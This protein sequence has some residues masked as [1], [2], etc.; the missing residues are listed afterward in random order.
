M[1]LKHKFNNSNNP[2]YNAKAIKE[3]LK[4]E[5]I[6]DRAKVNMYQ[7]EDDDTKDDYLSTAKMHIDSQLRRARSRLKRLINE[8]KVISEVHITSN[9][10]WTMYPEFI[11]DDCG[12]T[13]YKAPEVFEVD[14]TVPYSRKIPKLDDDGDAMRDED[15]NPIMVEVNMREAIKAASDNALKALK[16]YR[17]QS[18]ELQ[19]VEKTFKVEGLPFTTKYKAYAGNGNGG[20]EARV[21]YKDAWRGTDIE[22]LK[23]EQK[24]N[25]FIHM[26]AGT[27]LKLQAATRTRKVFETKKPLT[28]AHHVGVEIEFASMMDKFELATELTKENV[29]DF[30]QLKD[31]GSVKKDGEFNNAHE[32]CIVAPEAIIHEVVKRALRAIN[33]DGKSKV[34]EK[35][36]AGLHIHLDMRGRDRKLCFHNLAKAQ[37]IL[38]A[39]NPRSRT[40]G[41]TTKG[42]KDVVWSKRVDSSDFDTALAES[43]RER[44]YGI[45]LQA[46]S[47][48][49]TIEIRIHS[50]STNEEK[51]LNW[52]TILTKIVNMTTKIDVEAAKAE[53]FCDY[54]GLDQT[55]CD[56]INKRIAKFKDSSGKHVTVDEAA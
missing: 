40:D 16:V 22:Q 55:I 12:R 17:K 2:R 43:S 46:L 20:A 5:H 26:E 35:V 29:Q 53:T 38:Y 25:F 28:D 52:I 19:S 45:N 13:R 39:M 21:R 56:Y 44:Y 27:F 18:R 34:G 1:T 31:D 6:L 3:A 30:V 32:L 10:K 7:G 54:Y 37:R 42:T 24:D 50:G 41:T 8:P 33:K 9:K 36:R 23:P 11:G 14:V 48:F 51:I 49:N 4:V 15:D 47:K